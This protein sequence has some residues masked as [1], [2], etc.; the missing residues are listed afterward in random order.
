MREIKRKTR[1]REVDMWYDDINLC[2]K[3]LQEY[4]DLI[5]ERMG[6][7][8]LEKEEKMYYQDLRDR[9]EELGKTTKRVQ[10]FVSKLKDNK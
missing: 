1:I 2:E 8:D 6:N 3:I 9:R 7:F 10:T 5:I 4:L